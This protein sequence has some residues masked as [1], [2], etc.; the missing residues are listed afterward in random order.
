[1]SFPLSA[2]RFSQERKQ[3]DQV[4]ALSVG[5]VLSI[6]VSFSAPAVHA[7]TSAVVHTVDG[8]SREWSNL[9]F[10]EDWKIVGAD[11]SGPV[12]LS[13]T[14]VLD[15]DL[16]PS[17]EVV[18]SKLPAILFPDRQSL[19]GT[20]ESSN[21]DA[22]L[23]KSPKFRDVTIP[24]LSIEGFLLAAGLSGR[25]KDLAVREIRDLTR[26]GD[27]LLLVNGDVLT[28][29]IETFGP[30]EWKISKDGQSRSIQSDRLRGAA[31]DPAIIEHKR[32]SGLNAMVR[33]TDGSQL[34]AVKL[35]STP[36]GLEAQTLFGPKLIL[37][38]DA[39]DTISIRDG[40]AVYLSDI[41]PRNVQ[42]RPFLDDLAP[43]KLDQ[44]VLGSPLSLDGVIHE[45]GIGA[46]GYSRMD[47]DVEGFA[48]FQSKI[49][50]DD[51]AGAM[52][53][54]LFQVLLD[55]KIVFDSGEMTPSDAAKDIDVEIGPAKVL[56]L[57]VDFATRGDIGDAAD[58]SA[59][60]LIRP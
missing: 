26:A 13:A 1:M 55:D 18:A 16:A 44:S 59:A 5:Y 14:E 42:T 17:A 37:R 3:R 23:L 48:R 19:H 20:I 4:A 29:T 36:S 53:S 45:K 15:I 38:M 41:E 34:T 30:A 25:A 9:A 27:A 21:A 56:S 35:L 49:G 60:R 10:R 7:E 28:G 51:A 6:L 12:E 57:V 32:P 43:P 40:R 54:V 22:V 2:F 39:V 52:A 47:Y 58:W 46:R 50:V 11:A 31:L 8:K 33:L 24:T